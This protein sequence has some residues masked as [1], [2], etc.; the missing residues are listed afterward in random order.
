[1]SKLSIGTVQFGLDYGVANDSGKVAYDEVQKILEEA[2]IN[3][4]DTID[5]AAAYGDSEEVL[6]KSG[7]NKFHIITK[8]PEIPV[9]VK[10]ITEYIEE[11]FFSSLRR[12]KVEHVY[13]YLLHRPSQLLTNS[14]S[15]IYQAISNLKAQGYIKKIGA[16]IYQPEELDEIVK[17]YEL[18]LV[19]VPFNIF[20]RRLIETGWLSQLQKKG[21]EIHIRS[22]FLQG[23]LLMNQKQR[24]E[25]FNRWN[26]LWAKWDDWLENNNLT[27]LEASIRYV[28]SLSEISKVVIGVDSNSQLKEIIA[29]ANGELPEIPNDLYTN[30]V[31]LLNPSNWGRL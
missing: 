25:K 26:K 30:D 15:E 31:N 1:V 5:T 6:G 3:Q 9:D 19:Q 23:L 27:P 20:D 7:V 4:I 17:E 29:A 22:I 28:L 21:V 10:N 24:P 16:S 13:G 12:L 2:Q 18:E 8:L 14:G 11:S